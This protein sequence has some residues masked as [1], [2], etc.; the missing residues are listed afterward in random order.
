MVIDSSDLNDSGI[1][2]INVTTSDINVTTS[3]IDYN[4]SIS[5][6]TTIASCN[7]QQ[8]TVICKKSAAGNHSSAGN[9]IALSYSCLFIH[10]SRE[11]SSDN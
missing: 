1:K 7:G 8:A 3:D 4:V 10:P 11:V 2:I 5:A 6:R 9:F